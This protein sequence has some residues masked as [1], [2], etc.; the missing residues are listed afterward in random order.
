MFFRSLFLRGKI[1]PR[2]WRRRRP[3]TLFIRGPSGE[4]DDFRRQELLHS[5]PNQFYSTLLT[6]P[7]P[8]NHHDLYPQTS[9]HSSD[10]YRAPVPTG[11]YPSTPSPTVT[12]RELYK[13]VLVDQPLLEHSVWRRRLLYTTDTGRSGLVRT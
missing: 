6:S 2:D 9:H 7:P 1:F 8:M 5:D 12:I 10:L 4:G 3:K 11:S 13:E